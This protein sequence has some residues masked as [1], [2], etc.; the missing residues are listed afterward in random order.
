MKG[1]FSGTL[2]QIIIIIILLCDSATSDSV[3]V[4]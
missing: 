2:E 1:V 3:A 4:T